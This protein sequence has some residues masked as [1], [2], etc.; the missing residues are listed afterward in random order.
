MG[1]NQKNKPRYEPSKFFAPVRDRTIILHNAYKFNLKIGD[2]IKF[3]HN[4]ESL[5]LWDAN[6]IL[7]RYIILNN[8]EFKDKEVL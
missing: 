8:F 4:F 7:S 6:I 1:N 2:V 3:P 5:R